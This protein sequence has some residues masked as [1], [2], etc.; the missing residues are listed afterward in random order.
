MLPLTLFA[1]PYAG[2]SSAIYRRWADKLPEWVRFV[3]LH[4]PGRGVRARMAP[5]HEWRPLLDLLVQ[6]VRA[7]L[8]RPY[9]IFGHSM[10]ALLGAEL[11]YELR[12]RYRLAP[13][14]LGVS[15]CIAPAKRKRETHWLNCSHDELM[16]EVGSLNG[17]APAI[18]E[19][20]DFMALVAPV[21]RADFHLCGTH[22]RRA[23]P[24]L[25]C[26]ILALGGTK[27]DEIMEEPDNLS[28]WALETSG[29]FDL[30]ML[31]ADHFYI[32]THQDEVIAR[33][34]ASLARHADPSWRRAGAE[35]PAVTATRSGER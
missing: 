35:R 33:V 27:D 31:D 5:I 23:L 24:P 17:T 20:E 7:Y 12:Q 32:N 15:A 4:M 1:L 30:Q 14:W 11:A 26:P 10:G 6:D 28:A 18:L 9:A 25:S 8:D 21:L 34:A 22:V 2:G 19:N 3:P 29:P 13:I 16:E